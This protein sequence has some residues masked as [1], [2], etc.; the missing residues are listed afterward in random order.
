MIGNLS[1]V[2]LKLIYFAK[3]QFTLIMVIIFDFLQM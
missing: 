2:W 3:L 1:I